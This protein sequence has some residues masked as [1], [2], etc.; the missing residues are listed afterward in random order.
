MSSAHT[1]PLVV[2]ARHDAQ[3]EAR[4]DAEHCDGLVNGM[5]AGPLA[6]AQEGDANGEEHDEEQDHEG[7]VQGSLDIGLARLAP[8]E[9]D[10][11][12]LGVC[13]ENG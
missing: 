13:V 1:H 9:R 7:A 2:E 4:K 8:A 3:S 5:P 12:V 11:L 6:E 10:A